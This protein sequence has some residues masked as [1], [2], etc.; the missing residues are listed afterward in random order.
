MTPEV[1]PLAPPPEPE[2]DPVFWGWVDVA[3]FIGA[4]L[5]ALVIAGLLTRGLLGLIGAKPMGA[6]SLLVAQFVARLHRPVAQQVQH[7]VNDVAVD[8]ADDA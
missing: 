5:P 3:M 7:A 6:V 4:V 8:P 1:T 2:P